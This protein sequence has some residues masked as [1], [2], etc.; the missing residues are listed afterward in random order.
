[1]F[2]RRSYMAR[3]G[4]IQMHCEKAAI[5]KNLATIAYYL[6]EAALLN[7]DIIGFPE[8]SLTGYADPNKYPEAV[9]NLHG[10]EVQQLLRLTEQ[11]S[12]TALVGL[13]EGNP[14]GKPF[15]TQI[16]VRRGV[17]QDYYRKITIKDEETEWFSAGQKVPV[18]QLG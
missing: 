9:L 11:Y 12:V 14:S 5:K 1:M 7:L 4:L 10:P 13:I 15:I 2:F 17:L 8:M 16:A 3:I 6:E 18:F